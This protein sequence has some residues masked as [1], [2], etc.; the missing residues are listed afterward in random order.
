MATARSNIPSASPAGL[1][2]RD[3]FFEQF[4]DVNI[5]V[6]DEDQQNLYLVIFRRLFPRL[7]INQIFP[8]SGKPNVLAHAL[9]P[10]NAGR[11]SRSVY[12]LDKDFDDLLGHMVN[13]ENVFYLNR[14]CIE[15]YLL[16]EDAV[17]ELV[18]E[19]EP[20]KSKDDLHAELNY[21][22]FHSQTL[23]SL[24]PLFRLF[25]TVQRFN[26]GLKNTDLKSEQFSSP[27][28]PW[29]IDPSSIRAYRTNVRTRVKAVGMLTKN[30]EFTR[31]LAHVFP[32]KGPRDANIS[33]KF[34]LAMLYHYLR[35]KVRLGNCRLDSLCFRL[36]K[37]SS[38]TELRFL[39]LRIRRFLA[40]A[41]PQAARLHPSGP[42]ALRGH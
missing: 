34:L 11:R 24:D 23:T 9:D 17:L 22:S 29:H 15:N 6:E 5:Y 3:V 40:T 37:N 18:L 25:F 39:R 26:L 33:G 8:L 21:G 27:G 20:R 35:T 7:Q 13:Q 28:K 10:V 31:F 1:A 16:G 36:A 38:L 14:Y 2:A 4:N 41:T 12:I 32:R 30:K 19:C 42:Q